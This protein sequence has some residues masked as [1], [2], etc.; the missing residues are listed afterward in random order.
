MQIRGERLEGGAERAAGED[1]DISTAR[2]FLKANRPILGLDDPDNELAVRQ[3]FTDE[4]GL[5]H[6]KFEQ[7]WHGL[8][9][10]PAELY[11][12][13]DRGVTSISW[14]E[15]MYSRHVVCR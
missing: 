3:H 13:L 1:E 4:I 12:H 14:R 11:V 10:W 7:R 2:A 5:K 15:H 9:V 6:V 8:A